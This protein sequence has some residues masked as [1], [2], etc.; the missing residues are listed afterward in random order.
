[1]HANLAIV[2]MGYTKRVMEKILEVMM[3]LGIVSSF[4]SFIFHFFLLYSLLHVGSYGV[5]K[6]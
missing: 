2:V 5:L 4:T 1:M 3:E 6:L